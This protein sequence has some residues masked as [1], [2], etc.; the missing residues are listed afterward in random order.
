MSH[1]IPDDCANM[2]WAPWNEKEWRCPVCGGH[3]DD[4][5]CTH[6]RCEEEE[7][8]EDESQIND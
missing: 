7:E 4:V 3:Q 5:K 1:N 2:P 8:Q 6:E